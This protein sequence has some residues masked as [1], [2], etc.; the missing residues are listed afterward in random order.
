[1]QRLLTSA[2]DREETRFPTLSRAWGSRLALNAAEYSLTEAID[3]CR[4]GEPVAAADILAEVQMN[5]RR[6]VAA[7]HWEMDALEHLPPV[8]RVDA[9]LNER[10]ETLFAQ[11]TAELDGAGSFDAN[12][13][14]ELT[15]DGEFFGRIYA[16]D[17]W[18]MRQDGYCQM[19]GVGLTT[20]LAFWRGEDLPTTVARL[21]QRFRLGGNT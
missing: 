6:V 8:W 12:G 7:E 10:R 2:A 18:V 21:A 1:L 15:Q 9:A 17:R 14:F 4:N 3:H 11:M 19:V 5:F 13:A 20:L 16:N